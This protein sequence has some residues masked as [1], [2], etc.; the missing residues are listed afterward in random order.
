[1]G[2]QEFFIKSIWNRGA[3]YMT[4]EEFFVDLTEIF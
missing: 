4:K 2:K 3:L 1:M